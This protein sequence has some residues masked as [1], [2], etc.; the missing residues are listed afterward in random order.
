MQNR[1]IICDKNA[2]SISENLRKIELSLLDRG[3]FNFSFFACSNLS[4]CL[5]FLNDV[6]FEKTV[7]VC[8]NAMID[9]VLNSVKTDGSSL[10]LLNEQAVKVETEV[11]TAFLLV[12]IELDATMFLSE[13]LP[14]NAVHSISIFGKN[15]AFLQEK[16]EELK[17]NYDDFDYEIIT[18]NQFLHNVYYSRFVD[19]QQLAEMLGESLVSFKA[20]DLQSACLEKLDKKLSVVEFMTDGNVTSKLTKQK[21]SALAKSFVFLS[22]DDFEE[23]GIDKDFVEKNGSVSKEMVFAMAKN[24]LKKTDGDL[25]M[26]VTGFDC[27]AGRSFVAVGNKN[28]I[29]VF[30]SVFYGSRAER[31][32]NITDFTCFCLLK[33]LKE[34]K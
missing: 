29:H 3:Q 26:A 20:Q 27:D 19:Q 17:K 4:D 23:L 18:L 30:S 5:K 13:F 22:E 25:A 15:K 21:A 10:T 6:S 33:F 12:P 7:I 32:E 8:P 24:L 16:F 11:E 1:V 34:D 14:M 31:M 2:L 28:V 9:E